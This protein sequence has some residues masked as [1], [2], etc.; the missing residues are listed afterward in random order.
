M[1][2]R[3]RIARIYRS[4]QATPAAEPLKI[5]VVLSGAVALG[6]FE[7]GVVYELL[8]A[9][10][11]GA[12]LT[13]DIV[14][15]SSV[16]GLVG[17]MIGKTLVTGVPFEYVLPKW[18]EFTLQQL[19]S[20]YETAEQAQARG[21]VLDR[22]ILSSES[23]RQILEDCLVQDPVDRTFQPA[24]PAP[25]VLLTVTLTNLD[26]L[27]GYGPPDDEYRFAEAVVFRFSPPDPHR[28]DQSP[29]PP[30][31][32]RRVAEVCRASSAFPGAFDPGPVPW[33]NRV[34]IPGLLEEVWENDPLLQRLHEQDPTI[35]PQMRYSDG[36]ILDEQPVERAISTLPMVT[37]GRG[38]AGI[39]T[40]VYDPRR[41]LLFIEPDPPATSLDALKAGTQQTW[42]S[43][44]TRAIRLWSLSASPNNSQT[45]ALINNQ[46]QE[47]LLRFLA[48]LA[49]R[50]REERQTL[51]IG[52]VMHQFRMSEPELT[53]GRSRRS[54]NLS[55]TPGLLDPVLY[56]QAI[57]EFYA[58]MMDDVRFG[59]D[60]AWLD[61]RPPGRIRNVHANYRA[62]LLSLR[63]AYRSL[64][65]VDPTSPGRFQAVLEDTHASLAE[66]LGLSQPWIA[67]HEITPDNPRQQL[68]GE[69]L[70][71]FGGFFSSDFLEHDYEVGRY[72]A[73]LW[74][75][76]AIPDYS[77][78]SEPQRP[79]I[80]KDGLDWK[81]VWR[82]R[83]PLWRM[84]GRLVGVLLE[85]VGVPYDGTAQ[86]VIRLLGWSLLL[87][88]VHGLALLVGAW[89]GWVV[90]PAQYEKYRFWVL[91]GAS[92]FPLAAGLALG[93]A[94]RGEFLRARVR[95]R[96][97]ENK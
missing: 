41:C 27:P 84:A 89:L 10:G 55:E 60:L 62:A 97:A 49:R 33:I 22:A 64:E 66:S 50:M 95:R 4:Y 52:Q 3:F 75:K 85:A 58:W 68:K 36:G 93:L 46:R 57:H 7:A 34:R 45:R 31:I 20:H 86:L 56:K 23:V 48:D 19:T 65:G 12:P 77:N 13:V 43:T 6:T 29:Y 38:E 42:F 54:T 35:Q 39:E 53:P 61:E 74:L 71:H 14:T 83:A 87:S 90:F 18:K 51:S 26:G 70:I 73:H 88:L 44:T 72:Y 91:I 8:A 81:L 69:E 47:R 9:V 79:P 40:L 92:M 94:L 1:A 63:E 2:R 25:R 28:L 59:R 37:G 11:R 16:G 76:E 21:K 30:A 82:N 24:Y 17:S 80:T 67:L 78:P 5:A 32:W 96:K 15:G